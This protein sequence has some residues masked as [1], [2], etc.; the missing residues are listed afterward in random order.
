MTTQPGLW[1]PGSSLPA[2]TTYPAR[3]YSIRHRVF[4]SDRQPAIRRASRRC[5]EQYRAARKDMITQ[6]GR[7]LVVTILVPMSS[8]P[9]AL[10]EFYLTGARWRRCPGRSS[11]KRWDDV[12]G[13]RPDCVRRRLSRREDLPPDSLELCLRQPGDPRRLLE[14]PGRQS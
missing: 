10:P 5:E 1:R 13:P 8:R 7:K 6:H 11:G 4:Q 2:K 14:R 3:Q 9:N 12:K